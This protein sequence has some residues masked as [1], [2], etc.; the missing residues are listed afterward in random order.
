DFHH[1]E[2]GVIGY[3]A[4]TDATTFPRKLYG[5]GQQV[6][7]YLLHRTLVG[8]NLDILIPRFYDQLHTAVFPEPAHPA[9]D[10]GNR[11]LDIQHF[12]GELELPRFDLRHIEDIIDDRQQMKAAFMD[13]LYVFQIF[14][15]TD[16]AE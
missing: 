1:R 8:P 13:I 14:L 15:I 11:G 10:L 6:E 12:L 7:E 16:R 3:D 4:N 5:I 9:A 2:C